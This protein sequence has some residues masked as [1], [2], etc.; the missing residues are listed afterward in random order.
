MESIKQNYLIGRQV[1]DMVGRAIIGKPVVI[2][3]YIYGLC[4]EHEFGAASG[5]RKKICCFLEKS[6]IMFQKH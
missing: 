3:R 6:S 5:E 2:P 1:P 4:Q